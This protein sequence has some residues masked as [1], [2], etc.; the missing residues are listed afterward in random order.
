MAQ[1]KGIASTS[2]S[3]DMSLLRRATS[4]RQTEPSSLANPAPAAWS[5]LNMAVTCGLIYRF[6]PT[7][8]ERSNLPWW[9]QL[10]CSLLPKSHRWRVHPL[11]PSIAA[12]NRSA[13]STPS[14]RQTPAAQLK[15]PD[16]PI[17]N[18]PWG[19]QCS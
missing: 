15:D 6:G 7:P 5:D 4:L 18:D 14:S 13:R 19:P 16:Q 9:K 17:G 11:A 2:L 3:R 12:F 1:A 10:A 8:A